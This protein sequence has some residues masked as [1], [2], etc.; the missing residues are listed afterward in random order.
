[1]LLREVIRIGFVEFAGIEDLGHLRLQSLKAMPLG[2]ASETVI[3]PLLPILKGCLHFFCYRS[4]F[5]FLEGLGNLLQTFLVFPQ[6]SIEIVFVTAAIPEHLELPHQV[7]GVIGV[8]AEAGVIDVPEHNHQGRFVAPVAFVRKF[9]FAM[10][11]I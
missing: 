11:V 8:I 1:L 4:V 5:P 9:F 7:F 3:D 2:V 10:I 6:E